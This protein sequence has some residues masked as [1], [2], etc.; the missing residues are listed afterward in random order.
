[1]LELLPDPGAYTA[2]NPRI[3]TREDSLVTR[4][5]LSLLRPSST[6]TTPDKGW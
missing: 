6:D 3:H 5:I 4:S 1:M 2:D